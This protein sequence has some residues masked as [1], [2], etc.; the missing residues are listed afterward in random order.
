MAQHD[1]AIA[2]QSGLGF[3][4]DLN[5]ALAAIVSQNSGASEPS[6]TYAYQPWA[7]TTTG[8]LKFRN[9]ANNGWVTVGTLGSANLGLVPSTQIATTSAAGIV[10]LSS[11]TS[12]TSTGLAATASAVKSA[13]DAAAA[14]QS[15]ADAAL[16]KAGGTMTG[17]I[18]FHSSQPRPVLAT[19]VASTSGTAIDF[20]SIPSWVKRVSIA[21]RG[22]SLSGTSN[23]L[24]QLGAG[25]IT[26]TGYNGVTNSTNTT[27]VGNVSSTAGFPVYT[28][29]AASAFSG[30]INIVKLGDNVWVSSH[31]GMSLTTNANCGGG[32]VALSG[33]LD[34]IR[35][36]TVNGTD[37]FD[38]G[39]INILYEG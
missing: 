20:T 28:S 32:D 22:V 7:D 31:A 25:S 14:A 2:N 29:T 35:I 1:Y 8:L 6:T 30:V 39:S 3:R 11:S 10:Q 24:V 18:V 13:Y 33:T 23:L 4:Q 19:S 36:T 21:C 38:A 17:E 12:S 9:A 26:T 27:G 15:T 37:T 5:N 34:R 16:P